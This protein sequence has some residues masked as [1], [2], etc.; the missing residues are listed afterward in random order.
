MTTTRQQILQAIAEMSQLYPDWRFGEI[1]MNVATWARTPNGLNAPAWDVE[2]DEFLATMRGHIERR[3]QALAEDAAQKSADG[4]S[5][6]APA[7][8]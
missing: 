6:A 2:D 4:L 8:K 1:V 3:R 5:Q 7:S